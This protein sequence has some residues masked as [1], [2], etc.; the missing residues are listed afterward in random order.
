MLSVST[1]RATAFILFIAGTLP[2]CSHPEFER[3]V[4][5]RLESNLPVI[6]AEIEGRHVSMVI[7]TALPSSVLGGIR[8]REIGFEQSR[9]RSRVYFRNLAGTKV[10]PM[11]IELDENIPADGLLGSDAW[12]GRTL[13]LDYRRRVAIL[14]PPG[15]IPEGFH[16]WSFKG[17]P[18]ISVVLNGVVLPAI[19]DS[20]I[21]DTAIIPE[22]LL[23]ADGARRRTV[24]LEVA[25]VE[26][27]DLDVL[28]G[29][30]GDIRIGNRVL[31]QFVVRIDYD[32]RT[33]ALWHD[34]R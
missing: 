20:A 21:P 29:P 31:S 11:V 18:R 28:T 24:D 22:A 30:T 8:A 13:T 26:F 32:H 19:I 16:S 17:P 23:E 6:D 4:A 2:A 3:N 33:V 9:W 7:A 1:L 12:R 14:N 10:A 34:S 27:D 5:F 25:G 15:P